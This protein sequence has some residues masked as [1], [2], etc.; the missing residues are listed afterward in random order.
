MT[1]LALL[2][3]AIM[4][5]GDGHRELKPCPPS[6][7]SLWTVS[8]VWPGKGQ[9]MTTILVFVTAIIKRLGSSVLKTDDEHTWSKTALSTY[10]CCADKMTFPIPSSTCIRQLQ[11]ELMKSLHRSCTKSN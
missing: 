6:A 8:G 2:S 1:S 7:P 11:G 3:S 10:I 4:I 9:G 5:T